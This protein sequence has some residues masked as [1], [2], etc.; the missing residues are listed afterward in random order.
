M[1]VYNNTHSEM[2]DYGNITTN[3]LQIIDVARGTDIWGFIYV[4][5]NMN[6][7]GICQGWC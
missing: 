3:H 6:N 5:P 2:S 4:L 1:T 7:I